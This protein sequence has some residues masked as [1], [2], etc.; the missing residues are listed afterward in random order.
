VIR[1]TSELHI[2]NHAPLTAA[3]DHFVNPLVQIIK[4]NLFHNRFAWRTI[5]GYETM[6]MIRKG[7]VEGV[8]KGDV[9][10]QIQFIENLFELAT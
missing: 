3:C 4:R 8:K 1:F 6:H 9:K 10:N 7:Q 5:R 2:H